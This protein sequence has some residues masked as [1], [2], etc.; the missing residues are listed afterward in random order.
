[1]WRRCRDASQFTINYDVFC[2]QSSPITLASFVSFVL[3]ES[4]CL[5]SHRWGGEKKDWL[6]EKKGENREEFAF[7]PS[8]FKFPL[9][10]L[11]R[12]KVGGKRRGENKEGEY[13]GEEGLI[14]FLTSIQRRRVC[15]HCSPAAQPELWKRATTLPLN[16]ER[17]KDGK[18]KVRVG[19]HASWRWR[20]GGFLS[21]TLFHMCYCFFDLHVRIW[22]FW[23]ACTI[24]KEN[25][26]TRS[27]ISRCRWGSLS[28]KPKVSHFSKQFWLW[29]G[30]KWHRCWPG[31]LLPA[32]P[33]PPACD[34][35]LSISVNHQSCPT[36]PPPPPSPD[37]VRFCSL[38]FKLLL[39][40]AL[41]D[42]KTNDF[43]LASLHWHRET[44]GRAGE[45]ARKANAHA[46]STRKSPKITGVERPRSPDVYSH[47]RRRMDHSRE[48]TWIFILG[49]FS[50]PIPPLPLLIV[51]ICHNSAQSELVAIIARR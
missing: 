5:C 13:G 14:G 38:S 9:P 21:C 45:G 12:K 47:P 36:P 51:L 25:N 50:P 1:M 16:G 31:G 34:W 6:R 22:R 44:L 23:G 11:R 32:P 40:A 42:G 15:S 43:S 37:P 19:E 8:L 48:R 2:R 30:N 46:A 20:K 3:M 26:V 49:Y 29:L 35:Q 33:A 17:M 27:S 39:A 41:S 7:T 10:R 24:I 4:M 18:R 28:Q